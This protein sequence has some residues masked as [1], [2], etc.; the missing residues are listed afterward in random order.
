MG[1]L[2]DIVNSIRTKFSAQVLLV[3]TLLIGY[4]TVNV[5][6]NLYFHPLARRF[7]GPKLWAAS[8]LPYIYAL[9]NGR[10]VQRQRELHE[11]YGHCI[12]L[13]PDEVS[14]ANEDAWNDIYMFRRGHKRALRDKAFLAAPNEEVDNII[15]TTDAKFHARVRGL[16]SNSFTEDSL[17]L[18]YPIIQAHADTLVAQLK[19]ITLSSP[20][21]T[22]NITDWL[23]FF[24]MDV[25]GDLSFGQPFGCLARGE[26]HDWVRTLFMYLKFMSLAAAP[27][28]YPWLQW[29]LE[30]LMPRSIMK[31][32]M[33]HQ[34]Y[35]YEKINQRLNSNTSRPDFMTAFL[36]KNSNFETMSRKEVLATF[37]FVIVGG[38]ETSATVL[39]GL[40]SHIAKNQRIRQRLCEEI[41]GRFKTQQ[42]IDIDE[43]KELPYLE[44]VLQEGLRVCN[45]V[46]CGLP[47]VVPPGGDSYCGHF[48]PAG[49]RLSARTYAINRSAE[50]FA[51]PDDFV[52]ERWLPPPERPAE[53]ANDK[54]YASRPF[55]VGFH[56]C[57]GKPL[58][59][60]ELRLVVAKLLWTF[61]IWAKDGETSFFEDFPILLMVQKGPLRLGI[62]VRE[63]LH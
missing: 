48:L 54:L 23:N 27:R 35:A 46:P 15:T 52:P 12:R 16:L 63:G 34:A 18:Q 13:A 19:R 9:V 43:I 11:K 56:A 53:F 24:T 55:S 31:G 59:W 47:R 62:K 30:W 36:K 26:Y 2:I 5:I 3:L 33:K 7:P 41:R 45:P 57:L 38:S 29:T 58:A 6:Y 61:D 42:D 49:T 10:L 28:Y 60:T 14:F 8:R 40:F 44:A 25:I 4:V 21:S 37:N 17:R 39:T 32:V 51:R 22:V 1:F 20:T 50:Y